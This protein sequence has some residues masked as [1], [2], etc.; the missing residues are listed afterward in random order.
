MFETNIGKLKKIID[1]NIEEAGCP[2]FFADDCKVKVNDNIF[3][4]Y[5]LDKYW[6]CNSYI[7]LNKK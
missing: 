4:L 1:E 6:R 3:N 5:C 7:K 2:F